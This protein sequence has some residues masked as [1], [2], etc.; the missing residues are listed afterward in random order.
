MMMPVG[1]FSVSSMNRAASATWL[2]C[3]GT[4]V[5]AAFAGTVDL[6]LVADEHLFFFEDVLTI[7]GGVLT[8][9]GGVSM[10]CDAVQ[11]FCAQRVFS[12]T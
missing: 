8:Q 9:L 4:S 3:K 12:D 6:E 2:G 5:R 10:L 11:C 1:S 7:A